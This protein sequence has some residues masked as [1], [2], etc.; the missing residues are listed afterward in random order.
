MEGVGSW[1]RRHFSFF[2]PIDPRRLERNPHYLT[3]DREFEADALSSAIS[4]AFGG[5]LT[6]S[7]RKWR[8]LGVSIGSFCL[9]ILCLA[10]A[11][12]IYSALEP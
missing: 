5:S 6:A 9:S 3:D 7:R 12:V 10:A 1:P 8:W 2:A 4:D 11:V